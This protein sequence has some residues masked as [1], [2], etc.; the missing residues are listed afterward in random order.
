MSERGEELDRWTL[1]LGYL[2]PLDS[3]DGVEVSSPRGQRVQEEGHQNQPNAQDESENPSRNGAAQTTHGQNQSGSTAQDSSDTTKAE[4][5]RRKRRRTREIFEE[6]GPLVKNEEASNKLAKVLGSLDVLDASS[7]FVAISVLGRYHEVC[8]PALSL[9]AYHFRQ[10]PSREVQK[11]KKNGCWN[12]G[13]H[14]PTL[15]FVFVLGRHFHR[16]SKACKGLCCAYEASRE[17]RRRGDVFAR[18]MVQYILP[19]QASSNL[20]D[21]CMEIR[22]SIDRTL[23]LLSPTSYG[24]ILWKLCFCYYTI[25]KWE[26]K[27]VQKGLVMTKGHKN[28]SVVSALGK[29]RKI[30]P[31]KVVVSRVL[32]DDQVW[33]QPCMKDWPSFTCSALSHVTTMINIREAK[34]R[35]CGFASWLDSL[36]M[37]RVCMAYPK[38]FPVERVVIEIS[39]DISRVKQNGMVKCLSTIL[40]QAGTSDSIGCTSLTDAGAK[41]KSGEFKHHPGILAA[42]LLKCMEKV[43]YSMHASKMSGMMGL[44]DQVADAYVQIIAAF[45]ANPSTDVCRNMLLNKAKCNPYWAFH[46]YCNRA[47]DVLVMENGTSGGK[48]LPLPHKGPEFEDKLVKAVGKL[49]KFNEDGVWNRLRTEFFTLLWIWCFQDMMVPKKAYKKAK[50][51]MEEKSKACRWC[52][53]AKSGRSEIEHWENLLTKWKEGHLARKRRAKKVEDYKRKRKDML[54]GSIQES[55]LADFHMALA[56]QCIWPRVNMGPEKGWFAWQFTVLAARIEISPFSLIYLMEKSVKMLLPMMERE[57]V[58][59]H[60]DFR[61]GMAKT[62]AWRAGFLKL[63]DKSLYRYKCGGKPGSKWAPGRDD[64]GA[65]M[66]GAKTESPRGIEIVDRDKFPTMNYEWKTRRISRNFL[67]PMMDE[68]RGGELEEKS[69]M[70]RHRYTM[71]RSAVLWMNIVY[72]MCLLLPDPAIHLVGWTSRISE[73]DRNRDVQSL[74]LKNNMGIVKLRMDERWFRLKAFDGSSEAASLGE[75]VA[76][77]KETT[78]REDQVEGDAESTVEIQKGKCP[79]DRG[80]LTEW[81]TATTC[82]SLSEWKATVT[83]DTLL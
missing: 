55:K 52:V 46:A 33:M 65:G 38:R 81:K 77:Q 53:D 27:Q 62:N 6:L 48:G 2:L 14:P 28:G 83:I 42:F 66:D 47:A 4:I 40:Q 71:R 44:L 23:G 29:A 73:W 39:K 79:P 5:V 16:P 70:V 35:Q 82:W 21:L 32:H 80:N 78:K 58:G 30:G 37:V 24:K 15:D 17:K 50:E 76:E 34:I 25:E 1:A 54:L 51:M 60:V 9:A 26:L 8:H 59:S 41:A 11:K 67:D 75:R 10:T 31:F 64:E 56:I 20:D 7:V 13:F 22:N 68:K 72:E 74:G 49:D 43:P 36:S 57:G 12:R 3:A 19:A 45:T 63:G 69:G 18:I 61:K